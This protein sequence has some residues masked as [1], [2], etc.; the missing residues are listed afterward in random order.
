MIS[1]DGSQ[2]NYSPEYRSFDCLDFIFHYLDTFRIKDIILN[3][4]IY[5][6]YLILAKSTE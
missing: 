3:I 1:S 5:N 6:I 2:C 4:S